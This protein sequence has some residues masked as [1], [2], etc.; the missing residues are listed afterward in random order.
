MDR[1]DFN[2]HTVKTAP[3]TAVG[4]LINAFVCALKAVPGAMLQAGKNPEI[5][6][7]SFLGLGK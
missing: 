7:R 5:S 1:R 3:Q 4:Y 6:R 2:T